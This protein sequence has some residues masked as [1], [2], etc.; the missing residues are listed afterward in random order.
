MNKKK[1][2]CDFLQELAERVEQNYA[3]KVR[4]EV[5]TSVKNNNVPVTG[6]LLK[7][8]EERMAPNFY[9][10]QQFVEWMRGHRTME[11]ISQR[12]CITYEEE[13]RK[14]SHL[15]SE[16]NFCWEDFRRKVFMRLI[17][18][19]KNQQLLQQIPHQDFLD[20]SIIYYYSVPISKETTGT[21]I[22]T[23]EHL[24]L[25]NVT[26]E[27]LH[28]AARSN[29]QRFQPAELRSMSEVMQQLGQR[30]G[31][32]VPEVSKELPLMFVFSNS[33]NMFGAVSMTFQEELQLF[34]ERIGRSF[35][36]LPSSVHEVILVPE[37]EKFCVEYFSYMVREINTTQVDATE[38][39]SDSVYYYDRKTKQL[40]RVA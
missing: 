32:T 22:V 7:G 16:I 15:V 39:L 5:V 37:Y 25:L 19:D 24:Q 17:N 12:L 21:M 10:E 20:L 30:S 4:G 28:L 2:Y 18:R 23:D 29:C 36:V 27:E 8:K 40:R 35:Y 33:R 38:V 6:L 9:L 14:S 26:E 11:E 34:A 1:E 3:G 13:I 31:I